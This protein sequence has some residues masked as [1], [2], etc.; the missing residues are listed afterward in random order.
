MAQLK[1]I[2]GLTRFCASGRN[3]QP[4]KYTIVNQKSQCDQIFT[5]LKW[6]GYLTDWDGPK[7]GERPTAYIVQFLDTN[8][9]KNPL[10]DEGLQLQAITL[11]AV[12][13]GYGACIIKSFNVAKLQEI[14]GTDGYLQP[15]YVVALG[16]PVEKV[17]IENLTISSE[18]GIKYYRD[19]DGTHHV[20]KRTLDEILVKGL[21]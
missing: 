5:I 1:E 9:T 10:C 3:L 15:T 21:L 11:G 4:L 16:K 17:V 7:E 20:P 13:M 18:E 6:A 12:A 14:L 2:V 19:T 8:I